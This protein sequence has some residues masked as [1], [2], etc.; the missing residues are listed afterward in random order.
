MVNT[1]IQKYEQKLNEV[2]A[3]GLRIV[4]E[5]EMVERKAKEK[6]TERLD[7][8]RDVQLREVRADSVKAIN[9][10]E[11]TGYEVDAEIKEV[12]GEAAKRRKSMQGDMALDKRLAAYKEIMEYWNQAIAAR[13]KLVPEMASNWDP[14]FFVN[15]LEEIDQ[16]IRKNLGLDLTFEG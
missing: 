7:A 14:H 6:V 9:D 12:E 16:R 5:R 13:Q 2:E 8:W 10:L 15:L 4:K 3:E 11:A 1:D